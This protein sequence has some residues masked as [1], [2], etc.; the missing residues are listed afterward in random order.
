MVVAMSDSPTNLDPV[1]V[2]AALGNVNR[3][4]MVTQMAG[5]MALPI[6]ELVRALGRSYKAVHKDMAVLYAAGAVAVR[7]G[8]DGRV[9]LFYIPEQYRPRP[10]V[11]DYGFCRL[12][13]GVTE[14]EPVAAFAKD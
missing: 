9:G 12:R 5:G 14:A 1:A 4:Q 6:N 8:E 2:L 3:L 13:F 11:V 10:G 7:Y